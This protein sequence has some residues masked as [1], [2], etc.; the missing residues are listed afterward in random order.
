MRPARRLALTESEALEIEPPGKRHVRAASSCRLAELDRHLVQPADQDVRSRTAPVL[1]CTPVKRSTAL[2]T[3]TVLVAYFSPMRSSGPPMAK[4]F[5]PQ[6]SA[7][8]LLG[9]YSKIYGKKHQNLR[10]M[11]CNSSRAGKNARMRTLIRIRMLSTSNPDASD[12]IDPFAARLIRQGR[13]G[14]RKSP[15]MRIDIVPELPDPQRHRI[16]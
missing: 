5:A 14:L 3:G 2:R 1:V 4:P 15:L 9:I 16:A 7:S 6:S 11:L 10:A 12:G 8:S 13:H